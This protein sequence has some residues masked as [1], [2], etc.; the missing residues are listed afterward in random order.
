MEKL[1][2]LIVIGGGP[3]GYSAAIYAARAKLKTLVIE[4][5]DLGGQ[6]KITSDVVNY[7][8]IPFISGKELMEKM[9][10]Q[11]EGF[12]VALVTDEV[13][14][15]DF[16]KDIKEIST[17]FNETFKAVGVAIATGAKPRSL[18][19]E[20]EAEFSGRGVGFCATCDGELFEG[21]DIFVIGAGF[22]AAQ[23]A[24]FLTRFARKVTVIAREPEF[25]CAKT[26]GDKVL[27]ND[28]IDVKFNTEVVYIK[29]TNVLK[30]AKFINNQT[31]ETWIYH[32]KEEDNTF[33][34][35]VFVG[36]EPISAIF[37]GHVDM[38]AQGYITTDDDMQTNVPG[39]YAAGDI[40][41]KRLRQLVTAAS[42]GA[43]ASTAIEKYIED[44]KRELGIAV[45]KEESSGF[46]SE[47][48]AGQIRYVME[49]CESAVGLSAIL[50]E[51]GK[52]ADDVR[53]FL[54]EFGAVADKV[55]VNIFAKGENPQLE[56]EIAADH[57]P[58]IAL[59]DKNGK[60]SGLNFHGI[61]GGHEL[62]SFILAIY[63][64]AGPG[65]RIDGDLLE[66]IK[67]LK[68]ANVKIGVS[69]SC[70][71]C[72]DVVQAC[73]RIASLNEGIVAEMIDMR[74]YPELRDAHSIMS[75]PAVIID[76][77]AVLF[78]KKSI[79]EMVEHLAKR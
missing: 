53:N 1:F 68:P 14:S 3:A 59:L 38:D 36:Y 58:V 19:F 6:I 20:G 34:V 47:Q 22:A 54:G 45:E 75:L 23:E 32:V 41:P 67:S 35:F 18:G 51:S 46:I 2:D 25:T 44:K 57:L 16:S 10:Q 8:G 56:S 76:D 40:R 78:G 12:G 73:Q 63:N 9:R 70:A 77:S 15:V 60:Y 28:K 26:L 27:A 62:E 50:P 52:L 21:K 33:G 24:I 65:Q 37:K 4:R 61:P 11:A 64:V 17:K 31:K 48:A 66:K 29:G 13:V 79:E 7:P 30:E 55:S 71:V 5:S 69:L 43:I 49:R 39:V 72:P 42:D 74:H